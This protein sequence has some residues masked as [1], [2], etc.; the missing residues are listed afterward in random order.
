MN[1]VVGAVRDHRGDR[2]SGAIPFFIAYS[3]SP[4]GPMTL[5]K[6]AGVTRPCMFASMKPSRASSGVSARSTD[7][8]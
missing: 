2:G 7:R 1:H 8:K 4:D 5:D 6:I 3:G